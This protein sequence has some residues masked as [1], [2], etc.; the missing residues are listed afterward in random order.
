[1][2]PNPRSKILEDTTVFKFD[3]NQLRAKSVANIQN[4][5]LSDIE[6]WRIGIGTWIDE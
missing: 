1:M 3:L 5:L 6:C 2:K 4:K